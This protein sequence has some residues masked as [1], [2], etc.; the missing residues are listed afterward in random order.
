[1]QH[2]EAEGVTLGIEHCPMLFSRDEWPGGKNLAISPSVWR[3]LFQELPSPHLG[4][5]FD[6]SHLVWQMIDVPRCVR[7]FGKRIVH[8]HAKD[9]RI[10]WDRL[11]EVGVLG[12]GWHTP[13]LPGLGDVPWGPFFSALTEKLEQLPNI[14]GQFPNICQIVDT[15]ALE[16]LKSLAAQA[17]WIGGEGRNRTDECSF[18][19]AVPY[20]LATPPSG[21][22]KVA[23]FFC[24]ASFNI[25][26]GCRIES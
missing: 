17:V 22:G 16:T 26:P 18:C 10:D 24:V 4:L 13:K 20:H 2:A 3:T 6:P 14:L 1:M 9:A 7:E 19:R 8:V 5:N 21:K 23:K 12:L 11:Y 25:T 15:C